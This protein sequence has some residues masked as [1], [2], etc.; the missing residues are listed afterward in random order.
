MILICK[1]CGNEF[2]TDNR[3]R[4]YCSVPCFNKAPVWNKGLRGVNGDHG[5]HNILINCEI[6]GTEF[7]VNKSRSV[8]AKFCSN[9]CRMKGLTEIRK[10]MVGV[11]NTNYVNGAASTYYRRVAFSIHGEKCNRCGSL[12]NL[13]VHHIDHNHN[14]NPDDGSNWEIL[15]TTCHKAHHS[16][17]I[18]RN[19]Y[20][21]YHD[22]TCE[23]CNNSYTTLN[24]NQKY[25]SRKCYRAN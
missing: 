9:D 23:R 24:K 10:S 21:K 11:K 8:K 18:K 5:K 6:C 4:K 25:C 13:E 12:D 17:Q 15:C 2:S 16:P 3:K 1:T 7:V 22:K 20:R 14:N 19:Y